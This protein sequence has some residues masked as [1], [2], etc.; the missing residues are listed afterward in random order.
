MSKFICAG[1]LV[2]DV[3]LSNSEAFAAVNNGSKWFE[4]LELGGKFNV[5]K[6]DFSTGGG[7]SNAATTFARQ[8]HKAT[9]LG[10]IGH[11]P[12][13]DYVITELDRE[14]ISTELITR[15]K[16]YNTGYSV[17]LLAP[18]GERTILTYRGASTYYELKQLAFEESIKQKADWLYVT[19][20]NGRMEVLK[21][22]FLLAK[23][24]KMMVAFN[25]GKNE[26]KQKKEMLNLLP[27]VDLLLTNKEEMEQIVP[28]ETS[29]ELIANAVKLVP[30]ASVTDGRHGAM[31]SDGQFLVKVGLY[32]NIRRP[33]DRTGAGDA[34]GSGL[35]VKLAEGKDL[36]QAVHFASA[37]SSEVCQAI[38]AKTNIL[39]SGAR[40]HAMDIKVTRL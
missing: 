9:V 36:K 39:R 15:T 37:N 34:F 8:G 10:I 4:K 22:L 21:K 24:Q 38:G 31:V 13:A 33:A 35:A 19:S 5:N 3:F 27:M 23:A 7:A 18:N 6:I 1:A 2:Q 26:L 29:R 28:G 30:I 14:G 25:P 12:A 16:K 40:I 32:D 17:I 11:D 20:L